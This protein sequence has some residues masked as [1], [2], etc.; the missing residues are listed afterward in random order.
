MPRT[1]LGRPSYLVESIH[2]INDTRKWPGCGHVALFGDSRVGPEV[3]MAS[4][5]RGFSKGAP[6]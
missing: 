3:A 1:V 2:W 4:A 6:C 5:Y